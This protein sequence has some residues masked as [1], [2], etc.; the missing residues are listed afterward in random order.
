MARVSFQLRR[1]VTGYGAVRYDPSL[2]PGALADYDSSLRADNLQIAPDTPTA[3]LEGSGSFAA[4]SAQ[5]YGEVNLEWQVTLTAVGDLGAVPEPTHTVLVYSPYGVPETVNSGDILAESTD[6]FS[7][8]HTGL[9]E[10]KWAYY[11]LFIRYQ[12]TGGDDY[13]EKAAGLSELVVKNYGSTLMLWDRIPP[14]FRREDA[15]QG[16]LNYDETCLGFSTYGEPVGPLL[17]FL[18][19]IGYEIDKTRTLIDYQ[20]TSRDPQLANAVNLDVLSQE[21]GAVLRN[22]HLGTSRLRLLMDNIGAFR[23]AKGTEDGTL[24]FIESV[25][26]GNASINTAT[27]EV[28]LYSQRANL[29]P[30]PRNLK[31][32]TDY[33]DWRPA[34]YDEVYPND[35]TFADRDPQLLASINELERVNNRWKFVD[36]HVDN[37]GQVDYDQYPPVPPIANDET[38]LIGNLIQILVPITGVAG[39]TIS[40]SVHSGIGSSNIVWA[41]LVDNTTGAIIA[42]SDKGINR[43]GTKFFDLLVPANGTFKVEFLAD[44]RTGPFEDTR[45]LIERNNAGPYFDGFTTRGGWLTGASTSIS[46]FRW[47]GTPDNS[48]SLYHEDYERTIQ[49]IDAF[50]SEVLPIDVKDTF[51]IVDYHAI[52]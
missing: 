27:R 22:G 18:S 46:D 34:D 30:D 17:K 26:G 43:Y 37:T 13:Y 24:F 42:S 4:S 9:P 31:N 40:F 19:V 44:L 16:D 21:L 51:T 8:D 48:P 28:T 20:M 45:F 3:L 1:P 6:R 49:A 12:S 35:V 36:G 50:L 41:R 7:Y 5:C 39:D 25:M 38:L 23:R 2:P 33:I 47:S 52:L 10:G 32:P 15:A 29:M 14:Y 11:G